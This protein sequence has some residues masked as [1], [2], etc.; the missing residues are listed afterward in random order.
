MKSLKLS[1]LETQKLNEIEMGML[2]GGAWWAV[3]VDG[4]LVYWA[5][6]DSKEAVIEQAKGFYGQ[7]ADISVSL[8][9]A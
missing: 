8:E 5:E 3:Y 2:N 4:Q 7:N 9:Q 1:H 6:S